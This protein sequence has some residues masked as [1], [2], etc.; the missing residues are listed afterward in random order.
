MKKILLFVLLLRVLHLGAQS[1]SLWDE[2]RRH[3]FE[4]GQYTF[5]HSGKDIPRHF[6]FVMVRYFDEGG[7]PISSFITLTDGRLLSSEEAIQYLALPP[8]SHATMAQV[9]YVPVDQV[10]KDARIALGIAAAG[11]WLPDPQRQEPHDSSK[12]WD[13]V[14][15]NKY[16]VLVPDWTVTAEDRDYPGIS[17]EQI[18]NYKDL[19][20]QATKTYPT[21]VLEKWY[22]P[23]GWE[24]VV[25]E[26][27]RAPNPDYPT[28]STQRFIEN[29]QWKA[30]LEARGEPVRLSASER[31]PNNPVH[32]LWNKLQDAFGQGPKSGPTGGGDGST[33][34]PPPP[35][36]I[37]ATVQTRP[38]HMEQVERDFNKTP[39]G[40][41]IRALPELKNGRIE[42]ARFDWASGDILLNGGLRFQTRL[43]PDEI[44][45]LARR[46]ISYDRRLGVSDQT[47]PVNLELSNPNTRDLIE[48]DLSL[49]PLAY[50]YSI[51][52]AFPETDEW[53][54][55]FEN[56]Y[57]AKMKK[58]RRF[59]F[60]WS[61]VM[62]LADQ[63]LR[64]EESRIFLEFN[65][66]E[67]QLNPAAGR[68]DVGAVAVQ[69]SY[70]TFFNQW[71]GNSIPTTQKPEI[72]EPYLA[73]AV[74]Y[75]Q[76]HY[77][78]L[79]AKNPRLQKVRL[80]AETY[81]LLKYLVDQN[82]RM[83][84]WDQLLALEAFRIPYTFENYN[85]IS[86][87]CDMARA[88]A[89]ALSYLNW[90][91]DWLL[92]ADNR[93]RIL[94]LR[95][96]LAREAQAPEAI[97]KHRKALSQALADLPEGSAYFA[98]RTRL[99]SELPLQTG[100][101]ILGK[102]D[103]ANRYAQSHP[104]KA[105]QYYAEVR[106]Y[107]EALRQ[108]EPQSYYPLKMLCSLNGLYDRA[109]ASDDSLFSPLLE[110]VRQAAEAG[111]VEAQ[112]TMAD[113][114][115]R[116]F[117]SEGQQPDFLAAEN[118]YRKAASQGYSAAW[119]SLGQLIGYD[120]RYRQDKKEAF[121]CFQQAGDFP[122]AHFWLG[123][124]YAY[125]A[126]T[127]KDQKQGFA[128]LEKSAFKGHA[129]AQY[130][131]GEAYQFGF[132]ASKNAL[133]A[134]YWYKRSAD[135]GLSDAAKALRSLES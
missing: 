15:N 50:G 67:F 108:L 130:F 69:I 24:Q 86:P 90:V 133:Q 118:W 112:M 23:G 113:F 38:E 110:R 44:A 119:V 40:I 60:N 57:L 85:A 49:G 117:L 88:A 32:A 125:A 80:L 34:P 2:T 14:T 94:A 92:S 103:F 124:C 53:P 123:F 61:E 71:T 63:A 30:H 8:N 56:P 26:G 22:R 78:A 37:R 17:R 73:A 76:H 48:A 134:R 1:D 74:D 81:A 87:D 45:Q 54:D 102:L 99:L 6:P 68:L 75:F 89:S 65:Q 135:Q 28:K 91:P 77:A 10:S 25:I 64:N 36:A 72:E 3:S 20:L 7:N 59:L 82:I 70:T 35:P 101:G 122:D 111:Q 132:G 5:A 120:L 46:A 104:A 13:P 11:H 19:Y 62:R 109:R 21:E 129:W 114:A 100:M 105:N 84:G 33:P 115:L 47:T 31:L 96:Q 51:R 116:G 18:R 126:G 29:T 12:P 52:G 41:V 9:W 55:G 39:G 97:A 127:D 16:F 131:L 27:S 4:S 58:I 128:F 107:F 93:L 43:R 98:E 66:V 79:E 42:S 95:L 106:Q 83:E 121:A